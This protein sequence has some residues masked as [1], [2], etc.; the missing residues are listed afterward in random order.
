MDPSLKSFGLWMFL[1]AGLVPACEIGLGLKPGARQGADAGAD[2]MMADPGGSDLDA[3]SD[4]D[5]DLG[6]DAYGDSEADSH[7]GKDADAVGDAG[8]GSDASLDGGSSD[9][10]EDSSTDTAPSLDFERWTLGAPAGFH[11]M[12]HLQVSREESTVHGGSAAC[13]LT[14]DSTSNQDLEVAPESALAWKG[15]EKIRFR[16]WVLDNDPQGRVRIG[17]LY[18]DSSRTKIG[19]APWKNQYSSDTAGWQLLEL[20]DTPPEGTAFVAPVMRC[21]DVAPFTSAAVLT[22]D[23]SLEEPSQDAGA[24]AA[25][26]ADA[27]A[28][29]DTDADTDGD[30]DNDTGPDS[31]GDTDPDAGGAC[32]VV[33]NELEYDEP[34]TDTAEFVE[35]R[36]LGNI[37]G[38]SVTGCGADRV[39]LFNDSTCSSYREI[40]LP[41]GVPIP[42]DGFWVIGSENVSLRDQLMGAGSNLIQNGAPDGILLYSAAVVVKRYVY[43]GQ[44]ACTELQG[45]M[46]IPGQ[47]NDSPDVSS[48]RCENGDWVLAAP[49]PGIPTPA[50]L[51]PDR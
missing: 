26:D 31:G 12:T 50:S 13:L 15:G 38:K 10:A 23:W 44:S 17:L 8:K 32:E 6:V 46:E 22:D 39:V 5:A 14:W 16:A 43:E 1:L 4:G 35:L 40:D 30:T 25:A 47:T 3:D 49:S 41:A 42:E 9:A 24:D 27:D 2:A 36:F 28:D 45:A 37:F 21:Y 51:C 7:A 20:S 19:A 29:A 33:L 48:S 18:Y 11:A 34:G